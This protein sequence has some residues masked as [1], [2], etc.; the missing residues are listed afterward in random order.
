MTSSQASTHLNNQSNH[1]PQTPMQNA[2]LLKTSLY[3]D[4]I[5]TA[6]SGLGLV[7]FNATITNFLGW[8]IAWIVPTLGIVFMLFAVYLFMAAKASPPNTF[9]VK[10]I[11]AVAVLWVVESAV[12]LFLPATNPLALST[13]GKW[14]A[15]ILADIVFLF[16]LT[17]FLGLRRLKAV[18]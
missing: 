5:F 9:I 2:S 17:Q 11:I 3:A 7:I 8:S 16:G 10:T 1:K 12:L 14:S 13:G 4:T 15:V 18:Q 6:V